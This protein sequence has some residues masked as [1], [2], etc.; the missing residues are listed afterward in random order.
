MRRFQVHVSQEAFDLLMA[1]ARAARRP[2]LDHGGVII[3]AWLGLRDEPRRVA[4][5]PADAPTASGSGAA[6]A[7]PADP[8]ELVE[9]E[10]A[11]GR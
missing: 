11:G 4:P 6:V 8:A 9:L 1:E 2:P 7:A 10:P 3:E 5:T